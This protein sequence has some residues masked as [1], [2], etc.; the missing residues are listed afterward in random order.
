MFVTA[1]C[2]LFMLNLVNEYMDLS[3]VGEF[4]AEKT[5]RVVV[6]GTN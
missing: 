3:N 2:L 5:R 6:D 4:E 1:V